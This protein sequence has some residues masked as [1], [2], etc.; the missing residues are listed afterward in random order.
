MHS[1]INQWGQNSG[2]M[3]AKSGSN[4]HLASLFDLSLS[5]KSRIK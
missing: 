4:Y 1:D 2:Q 3:L 5:E